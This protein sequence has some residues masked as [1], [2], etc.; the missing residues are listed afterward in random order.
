M[1]HLYNGE[2]TKACKT[3]NITLE[4]RLKEDPINNTSV[5]LAYLNIGNLF[6]GIDHDVQALAYYFT[7][8]EI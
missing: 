1:S 3:M 7:A 8:K 4:Y 5:G 6:C 2:I